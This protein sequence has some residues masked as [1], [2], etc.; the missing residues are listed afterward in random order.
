MKVHAVLLCNSDLKGLR[1]VLQY[2]RAY[3]KGTVVSFTFVYFP[4]FRKSKSR[5]LDLTPEEPCVYI[6]GTMRLVM[7]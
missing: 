4:I 6:K 2:S 3:L 1:K 5:R 7:E